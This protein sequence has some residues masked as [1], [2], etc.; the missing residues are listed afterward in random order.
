[1]ETGEGNHVD[2]ELP[3]IGIQLTREPK[4]GGDAG[5][6][7]GDEMVQVTIS[8]SG[9]FKGAEANVIEGLVV[10]AEGLVSVLDKLVDWEGG[11]VGFDH[12]VTDFGGWDDW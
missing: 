5:H 6:S 4:A 8:G 1:M 12:G 2:S 11:I 10:N 3:Q 9:Q 7:K